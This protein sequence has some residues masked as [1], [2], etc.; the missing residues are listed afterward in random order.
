M[1]PNILGLERL[2]QRKRM[3]CARDRERAETPRAVDAPQRLRERALLARIK[4]KHVVKPDPEKEHLRR[5]VE[6]L[7]A[8][9]SAITKYLH[10]LKLE[11]PKKMPSATALLDNVIE[12]LEARQSELPQVEI[13]QSFLDELSAYRAH[14]E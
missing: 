6:V 1:S 11:E 8:A 12:K 14:E 3:R 4:V 10:Q 2:E 9:V 5:K 13:T 7:E